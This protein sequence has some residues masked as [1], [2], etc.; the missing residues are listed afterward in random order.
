MES[1]HRVKSIDFVAQL[2]YLLLIQDHCYSLGL[3]PNLYTFVQTNI[4][5]LNC[6]PAREPKS[7]CFSD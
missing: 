5:E 7:L 1:V 6:V 4:L 2:C 3:I